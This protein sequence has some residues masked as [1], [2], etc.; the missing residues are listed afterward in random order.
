MEDSTQKRAYN[1]SESEV[2]TLFE[3]WS[4][5]FIQKELKHLYRNKTVYEHIARLLNT[6]GI[7]RTWVQCK[8]KIKKLKKEFY[9]VQR[10]CGDL[11]P[12]AGPVTGCRFYKELYPLL[13][14]KSGKTRLWIIY[15]H[16]SMRGPGTQCSS[17]CVASLGE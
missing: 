14:S 1:W 2:L 7:R 16:C 12:D 11:D 5:P 6:A 13:A 4:D 3:L 9:R 17:S 10:I 8:E 15:F